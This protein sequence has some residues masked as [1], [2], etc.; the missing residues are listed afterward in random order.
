[1]RDRQIFKRQYQRNSYE[2]VTQTFASSHVVLSH[3][4]HNEEFQETIKKRRY[5]CI[6]E[7]ASLAANILVIILKD[8]G[9]VNWI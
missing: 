5:I 6:L 4:Y 7:K 3:A 2:Q 9:S 8:P 1:M